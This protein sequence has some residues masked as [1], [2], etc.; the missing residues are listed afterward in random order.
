MAGKVR[1]RDS[2]YVCKRLMRARFEYMRTRVVDTGS[3]TYK[4]VQ[5]YEILYRYACIYTLRYL[6]VRSLAH[7][8]AHIYHETHIHTYTHTRNTP[9]EDREIQTNAHT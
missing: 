9:E 3:K 8:D 4:H 1:P 5:V 7:T 2:V 6:H